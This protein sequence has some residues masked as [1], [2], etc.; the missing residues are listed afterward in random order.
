[1]NST[2]VVQVLPPQLIERNWSGH[3]MP[4][5]EQVRFEIELR[6][7]GLLV[8]FEAPYHDDPVPD[9][10]PGPTPG[11]W[12]YEV[13]ELFIANGEQYTE[14][15]LGP[16][17]HYLLLRL[18]GYRQRVSELHEIR[19]KHYRVP[20]RWMGT[21]LIPWEL[22]PPRPWTYNAYAIHGQGP[23]RTYLARFPV[24]GDEPDFHRLACFA[25]LEEIG[26]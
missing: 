8:D 15:E 21:A 11:L 22:L 3:A 17:G 7:K 25:P 9:S 26:G 1:M 14:L 2:S 10:P 13:F 16:H 18:K 6:P 19:Y 24:P 4:A 20:G 12:D 23:T 5:S